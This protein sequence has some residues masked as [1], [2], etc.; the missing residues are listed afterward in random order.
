LKKCSV[1]LS[2]QNQGISI[3]KEFIDVGPAINVQSGGNYLSNIFGTSNTDNLKSDCIVLGL[4]TLYK[5]LNSYVSR[6]LLIDPT[7]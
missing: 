2:A 1:K 4:G 3:S 7:E 6:T 5:S